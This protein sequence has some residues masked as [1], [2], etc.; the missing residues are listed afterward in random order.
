M[1]RGNQRFFIPLRNVHP[2]VPKFHD[3]QGHLKRPTKFGVHVTLC[4]DEIIL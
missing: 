2:Q 1:H 3:E 4:I